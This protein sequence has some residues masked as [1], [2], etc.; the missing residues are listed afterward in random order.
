MLLCDLLARMSGPGAMGRFGL[1]EVGG[2]IGAIFAQ[3][4][5][6]TEMIGGGTRYVLEDD[7]VAAA[8]HVVMGRPR[9]MRDC[10]AALR[11]PW[12]RA[13]V[14]WRE[15]ARI[16]VRETLGIVTENG[17]PPPLR[18][19]FLVEADAEGRR[20]TV[21][22]AW[23]HA[24]EELDG[25]ELASVSPFAMAFDFDRV[26]GPAERMPGHEEALGYRRWAKSPADL[27]ALD[28]LSTAFWREAT[29]DGAI[30]MDGMARDARRPLDEVL[31]EADGDLVG[32]PL[33][34]LATVMLL[35]ARGAVREQPEDRSRLNKSRLKAR[36]QPLLDHVVLRMRLSGAER[37]AAAEAAARNGTGGMRG[38]KHV[39]GHFVVRA[40]TIFWRRAHYR[41]LN[42][43]PAA[44]TR[45]VHVS[46]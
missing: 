37:R 11:L 17:R 29:R 33:S 39:I 2:T 23:S 10:A 24:A 46:V 40:R 21:R 7:V 45:T 36:K 18:F 8:T 12:R 22:F 41:G 44:T 27:D 19:G 43:P 4:G 20:G 26:E 25:M 14:E 34:F 13:W 32:E 6:M 31:R 28:Q 15:P 16:A 38:M 30:V 1:P 5:M 9:S 35:S 42:G 3:A